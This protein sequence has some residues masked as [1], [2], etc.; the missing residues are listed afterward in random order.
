MAR[1]RL[2]LACALFVAAPLVAADK[3]EIR[4]KHPARGDVCVCTCEDTREVTITVRGADG[5][6]LDKTE[7]TIVDACKF[8]Q[9]VIEK[10]A[11]KRPT[12]VKR[13]YTEATRTVGDDAH[14]L[15]YDGQLVLIERAERGYRFTIDDGKELKGD[16]AGDLPEAFGDHLPS[17]EEFDAAILPGNAVAVG[18]EWDIGPKRVAALFARDEDAPRT[19]DLDKANATGKL[20]KAYKKDGRQFGVLDIRIEVP[21]RRFEGAHPCRA[22]A[23][24]TQRLTVD[25]CIDGTVDTDT[26]TVV[27]E[28]TGTADVLEGGKPSGTTIEFDLR[29]IRRGSTEPA[30]K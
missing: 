8:R 18:E 17:D 2:V 5:K 22:G 1:A 11:G 30:S 10:A 16:E 6:V 4:L 14:K 20:T 7:E 12:R 24:M 13:T 15:P 9:E 25:T 21:L 26:G 27:V 28:L 19:F 29:S 23:K 3:F